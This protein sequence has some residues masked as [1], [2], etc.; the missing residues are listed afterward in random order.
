MLADMDPDDW[1]EWTQFAE[2]E[3]FGATMD[4]LYHGTVASLLYNA[5]RGKDADALKPEDFFPHL[6]QPEREPTPE[7]AAQEAK[8]THWKMKIAAWKTG[9]VFMPSVRPPG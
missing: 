4:G 8:R 9:N 5:N 6:K 7:Q 1:A 2:L 3:P